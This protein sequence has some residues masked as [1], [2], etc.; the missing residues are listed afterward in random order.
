M[1]AT[2]R[3]AQQFL[4]LMTI[5]FALSASPMASAQE[6]LTVG[7]A[8]EIYV[9]FPVENAVADGDRARVRSLEVTTQAKFDSLDPS[10][11][12]KLT[13]GADDLSGALIFN[14]REAYIVA[15]D[16]GVQ[17]LDLRIGKFFLPI[18]R[19]NQT[20]RSAWAFNSPP[21]AFARFFDPAGV[22]D[23]GFDFNYRITSQIEIRTGL[24]NGYRF[25]SSIQN[26]GTRPM[27]PTHYLR[28]QIRFHIGENDLTT[29]LNYLARVSDTGEQMRLGGIDLQLAPTKLEATSWSAEA[30]LYD[31]EVA[32]SNL[33][34]SEDAG[35]YLY[36][37]KGLSPAFVSG[38]R[39]DH[40]QIRSLADATGNYRPNL[41]L[42]VAPIVTYR[43]RDH[44]K[45]QASYTYLRE[46]RAMNA[47]RVEQ[48]I[49]FRLIT[50]FGDI[51]K[52]RNLSGDP[53]LL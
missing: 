1:F 51:P 21:L 10:L 44:L 11:K 47:N 24:T 15:A 14:I 16:L 41:I 36:I 33:P 46:T 12:G 2:P 37:E 32:P 25:D 5:L 31:R 7:A 49:E 28:P 27:T 29:G 26:G 34:L 35:G 48:L 42:A 39:F 22:A 9:P 45:L 4:F 52:F 30:E 20:R 53:S 18:G 13:V 23:T 38:L 6:P 3:S 19:L 50:E 8:A 17:G 43:G 40:Y